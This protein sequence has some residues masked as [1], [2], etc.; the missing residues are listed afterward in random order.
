MDP[1]ETGSRTYLI[2]YM[3]AATGRS[4]AVLEAMASETQT[5]PDKGAGITAAWPNEH[6]IYYLRY[7]TYNRAWIFEKDK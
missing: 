6:T 4:E 3:K 5:I 1:L 2:T 7:S